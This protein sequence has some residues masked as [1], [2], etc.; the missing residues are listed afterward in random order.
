M[1]RLGRGLRGVRTKAGSRPIAARTQSSLD[2]FKQKKFTRFEDIPAEQQELVK[3][4]AMQQFAEQLPEPE[5]PSEKQMILAI[6]REARQNRLSRDE[7]RANVLHFFSTTLQA[8]QTQMESPDPPEPLSRGNSDDRA[9]LFDA[10]EVLPK[11]H[12]DL[13]APE[14]Y[15]AFFNLAKL[16][17]VADQARDMK[18]VCDLFY[19]LGKFRVDPYNEMEYLQ[20]LLDADQAQRALLYWTAR[21]NHRSQDVQRLRWYHEFGVA[22]LLSLGRIKQAQQE[23]S[24]IVR[25]FGWLDSNLVLHL[26]K[27]SPDS[28]TMDRWSAQLTAQMSSSSAVLSRDPHVSL[29][30]LTFTNIITKPGGPPRPFCES[31]EQLERHLSARTVSV[32]HLAELARLYIV[33]GRDVRG[34]VKDPGVKRLMTNEDIGMMLATEASV[35]AKESHR[36]GR[37]SRGSA[38]RGSDAPLQLFELI[39]VECP[40]LLSSADFYAAWLNVLTY[41]DKRAVERVLALMQEHGVELEAPHQVALAAYYLK[42]DPERAQELLEADKA[43]VW[44]AFLRHYARAQEHELFAATLERFLA[45]KRKPSPSTVAAVINYFHKQKD[46]GGLW[47]SFNRVILNKYSPSDHLRTAAVFSQSLYRLLWKV[48]EDYYR[49]EGDSAVN[50]NPSGV[51]SVAGTTA[52]ADTQWNGEWATETTRE[53]EMLN[54]GCVPAPRNL[55]LKMIS[56]QQTH[57]CTPRHVLPAFIRSG[58]FV[59]ALAVLRFYK[60][61]VGYD[62]DGKEASQISQLLAKTRIRV[63]HSKE[64]KRPVMDDHPLW[65]GLEMDLN[66]YINRGELEDVEDVE[67]VLKTLKEGRSFGK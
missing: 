11:S 32:A 46:F 15:V 39:A 34:L 53:W 48:L 19:P 2:P 27:T 25:D 12:A 66:L 65:M 10:L 8:R 7:I 41:F 61:V 38:D 3:K 29:G 50:G 20:L 9:L 60:D 30:N 6:K 47:R 37:Q 16:G 24:R 55:F 62:L 56:E 23:A 57:S 36:A 67:Q 63:F 45:R 54:P 5:L 35:V 44:G 40:Q 52:R 14:E 1:L 31:E 49:A 43:A 64:L 28:E 59:G 4:E 33:R 42:H 17:V 58:D 18:T 13:F 21:V 22:A 51:H 26:C